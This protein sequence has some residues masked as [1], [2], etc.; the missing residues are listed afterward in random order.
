MRFPNEKVF[1]E[2]STYSRHRL[3]ERIIKQKLIEYICADCGNIGEWNGKKLVLHLEHKNG[4]SN[5]HRLENLTFL[6]P[7]CHTQTE[8]Y[9]RGAAKLERMV[10]SGRIELPQRVPQTRVLPLN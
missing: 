10:L 5:D 4:K 2:N 7:N 8:T 3:K 6:C 9:S 1:V